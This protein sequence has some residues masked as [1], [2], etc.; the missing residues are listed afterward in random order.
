MNFPRVEI[1]AIKGTHRVLN[2]H[3]NQPGVLSRVNKIVSDLEANIDA[4][5]LTTDP[6]IGYLI[7][8]LHHDVAYE[9][10]RRIGD[11]DTSIRTRVLY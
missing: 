3:L 9:V 6:N 10:A 4:Q 1:P 7:M 11:L 2:V 5:F 8:D